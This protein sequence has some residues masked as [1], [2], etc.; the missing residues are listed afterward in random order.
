MTITVSGDGSITRTGGIDVQG[1]NTNDS[2]AAGEIGEYVESVVTAGSA[3][4]S[5]ASTQYYDV[6]SISLTAGD[7]D[8]SALVTHVQNGATISYVLGGIG[9]ATGNNSAGLVDGDT[10][11]EG[12][13]STVVYHGYASIP[14]KRISLAATT[15]YYLKA[16][17]T[18]SAGAPKAAGRISARRVR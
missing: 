5:P 13:P 11:A 3:V 9:T 16:A 7:W 17:Q 12:P 14:P 4:A 1:T 18:Y 8:V 6:T 15:T 2:A 10:A